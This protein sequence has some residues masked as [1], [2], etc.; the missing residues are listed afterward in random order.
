M[1]TDTRASSDA[2]FTA[3]NGAYLHKREVDV[4][5]RFNKAP[6]TEHSFALEWNGT[7]NGWQNKNE[8]KSWSGF[9]LEHALVEATRFKFQQ[10]VYRWAISRYNWSSN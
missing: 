2:N 10:T 3:L 4:D 8:T 5:I 6:A 7:E 9:H 1:D